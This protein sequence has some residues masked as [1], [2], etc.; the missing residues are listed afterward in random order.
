M[1]LDQSRNYDLEQLAEMLTD[2]RQ[3]PKARE[4]IERTMYAIVHQSTP[5]TSLRER[6]VRA[7]RAGDTGTIRK[8]QMHIQAIRQQETNGREF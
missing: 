3:T 1:A 8:I 4:E 2:T 5:I 7:V 6:L